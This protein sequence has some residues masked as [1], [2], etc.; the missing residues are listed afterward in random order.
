MPETNLVRHGWV[1]CALGVLLRSACRR[2][3]T[4]AM[5]GGTA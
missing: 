3:Q 1:L 4:P 2:Q 5:G